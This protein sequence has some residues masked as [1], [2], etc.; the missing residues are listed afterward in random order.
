MR[1]TGVSGSVLALS[2]C[3][4]LAACGGSLPSVSADAGGTTGAG[5]TA[6]AGGTTGA[7]GTAGAGAGGT[8]GAAGMGAGGGGG[9]GNGGTGGAPCNTVALGG[10]VITSIAAT[11]VVPTPSGGTIADGTYLLTKSQAY[12]PA[13]LP[14]WSM[15][16]AYRIT[17][18]LLEV[19]EDSG[20]GTPIFAYNYSTSTAGTTWYLTET[21]GGGIVGASPSPYTATP[22]TLTLIN[23][24]FVWTF[25][26]Q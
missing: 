11:G 10:E 7:A 26:R 5:G 20:S 19:A 17:G 4:W 9:N 21:C 24:T 2:L 16:L 25:T 23:E 15:R 3:C 12:P 22:T 14:S 8:A 13:T 18:N 1:G 6:G